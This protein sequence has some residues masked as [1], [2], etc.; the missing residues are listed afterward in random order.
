MLQHAAVVDCAYGCQKE[1][2]KE[3]SEIEENR[4][5]DGDTDEEAVEEEENS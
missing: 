2:Q 1:N 3:A 4:R 5:K